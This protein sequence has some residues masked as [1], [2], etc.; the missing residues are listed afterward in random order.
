MKQKW[1]SSSLGVLQQ[2]GERYRRRYIENERCA[3]APRMIRGT[4]VHKAIRTA[5]IRQLDKQLSTFGGAMLNGTAPYDG[6]REVSRE[7][8]PTAEEARDTAADSIETEWAGGVMLDEQER[9]Q[10]SMNVKGEAK[11]FAVDLAGFHATNVAPA[12][13]PVG[14]ER[15][16]IVKP[17]DSDLEITGII[18]LI[19]EVAPGEE[20]VRDAKTREKSPSKTEADTSQ[21]LDIYAMIR[22]AETGVPPKTLALDVLVRTPKQ[23]DLKYVELITTR[24]ME[25]V[26]ALVNRINAA[27]TAVERGVFMPTD[28]SNWICSEKWCEFYDS[29]VYVR[30]GARPKT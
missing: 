18:D 6:R 21:Q 11:D 8:T 17:R 7:A 9:S 29:C 28:P 3:P 24:D 27:T 23:K 5:H 16:I 4:A 30:R 10:G 12:V 1:S 14:V 25:D 22:T 15:K 13:L 2:C 26:K 19:D 20:V